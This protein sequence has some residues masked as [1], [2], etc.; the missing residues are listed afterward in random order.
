MTIEPSRLVL[1][2]AEYRALAQSFLTRFSRSL[3]SVC[4]RQGVI[5]PGPDGALTESDLGRVF[6]VGFSLLATLEDH[7]GFT[8]QGKP[9]F[10]SAVFSASLPTDSAP[11][12]YIG[13][14]ERTALHGMLDDETL[15]EA[16]AAEHRKLPAA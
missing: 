2:D 3:V 6:D 11:L 14:S 8:H 13:S 16:A 4:I 15:Q 1:D 10:V 5:Q 7:Q 9:A 12:S